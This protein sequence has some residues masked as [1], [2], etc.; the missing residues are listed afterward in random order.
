MLAPVHRLLPDEAGHLALEVGIGDLVAEVAH[1][2]DEEVLAV[3]EQGRQAGR[4]VAVDQ[5]AAGGEVL[6]Q[7]RRRASNE[8]RR[9]GTERSALLVCVMVTEGSINLRVCQSFSNCCWYPC[10]DDGHRERHDPGTR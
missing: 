7:V 4:Q 5:V 9:V 1:R 10:G 3:G 2:A 8:M 6:G